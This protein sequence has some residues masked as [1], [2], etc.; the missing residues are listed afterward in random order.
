MCPNTV[1][2]NTVSGVTV[3]E[4]NL[5]AGCRSDCHG[6]PDSCLPQEGA[7]RPL[8]DNAAIPQERFAVLAKPLGRD[9]W[10]LLVLEQI[11]TQPRC[12]GARQN[13]L[14]EPSLNRFDFSGICKRYLDSNGY[15]LRSGGQD[16]GT[17]FRFRLKQ[18]GAS[19]RLEALDPQQRAPLLVGQARIPRRDPNGFVPLQLEPGWALERRV[20]Q[21]RQLNHLYFAHQ[22][23][24]NR[25]LALANSRG[26][27]SGFKRLGAPMPPIAP[28]PLPATRTSQRRTTR[29][30]LNA[31]IRLQVI[32]YRR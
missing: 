6:A 32:P 18:S 26:Q 2:Y 5:P 13:G 10:K 16:L 29:L 21:R 23:P 15:S 12:W 24:V 19:L 25:L 8:F 22:D 28:P 20:Y 27:R 1:R 3:H 9:Q 4:P 30:A 17:R 11:K 14:V 7:A 31:P